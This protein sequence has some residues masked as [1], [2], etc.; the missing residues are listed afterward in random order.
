M[1]VLLID[2]VDCSIGVEPSVLTNQEGQNECQSY[3]SHAGWHGLARAVFE[4]E[5][6]GRV[7]FKDFLATRPDLSSTRKT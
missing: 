2:D 6:A 7:W 5:R 3:Q 1:S 4:L